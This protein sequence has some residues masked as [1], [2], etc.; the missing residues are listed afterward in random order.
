MKLQPRIERKIRERK[1]IIL[2]G[3]TKERKV[4]GFFFHLQKAV[5][6]RRGSSADPYS[7]NLSTS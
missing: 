5:C 4:V 1:E 2:K 7:H 6:K 3:G